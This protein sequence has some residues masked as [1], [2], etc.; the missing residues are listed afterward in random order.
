M[1]ARVREHGMQRH[2]ADAAAVPGGG[3]CVAVGVFDA[4]PGEWVAWW[5]GDVPWLPHAT[6][7]PASVLGAQRCCALTRTIE[8]LDR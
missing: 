3:P 8:P 1:H 4:R 7:N 2:A 5:F 6:T